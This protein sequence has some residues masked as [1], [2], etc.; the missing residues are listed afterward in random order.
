MLRPVPPSSSAY[1]WH[2]AELTR[3]TLRRFI[4]F[5]GPQWNFNKDSVLCS[6]AFTLGKLSFST[7]S[8]VFTL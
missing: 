3:G 8:C 6:P 4:V 7:H 2:G 5:S 1:A